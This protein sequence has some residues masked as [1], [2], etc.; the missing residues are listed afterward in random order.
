MRNTGVFVLLVTGCLLDAASAGASAGTQ[1]PGAAQPI[2]QRGEYLATAGDCISCHTGPGGKPFA[3]GGRLNTPFGYLLAP[4]ITPDPETGIG[5]WTADDFYRA[6]HEG[7][8]RRGQ[9]MFPCMP[10]VFYTR[11]TRDDSD[12]IYAYLRALQPVRNA[13]DV[14]H[15]RF[16]FDQRWSMAGW[17]ELFF[18][19]GTFKSD[20]TASDSWNRGAYLVEGLGHCS[21]CHS[22]RDV[23]GGIE[24]RH[25]Y[26]GAEIDGWFAPN[27][28]SNLHVGLG[29]WTADEI[30][31]Y[32]KTGVRKGKTTTF[33]PMAEVVHN[34]TSKLTDADLAAMAQYLKTL[35]P[36]SPLRT[37][38]AVPSESQQRG[39]TLYLDHCAACHQ[40][41]GRG[42][43]GIFPPLAG[44]GAVIAGDPGNVLQAMLNGI[45]MQN[46][47]I[48]MP[49]FASQLR[50]QQNA[51]IANYVRT[52]WGNTAVAN[53]SAPE[54]ARLRAARA[55]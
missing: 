30:A 52:S 5:G 39:A 27:I 53:A 16:P 23:A 17:R 18:T 42:M 32:L 11:V 50:D 10:F 8:N 29:S 47:Y 15:L 51:A 2:E 21:A 38:R 4:N 22:P 25:E 6:M 13:V 7:V 55:Q 33:G 36:E 24:T 14:N 49:S 40:A 20:P 19:E 3:G 44:N 45:P 26:T 46:G 43:P 9:D 1:S 54:V 31:T 28:S 48:P 12:A 35:P 37:A 41:K 34:S